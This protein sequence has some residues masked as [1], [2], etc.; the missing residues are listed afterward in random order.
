[1]CRHHISD[2]PG[3]TTYIDIGLALLENHAAQPLLANGF[4]I[5]SSGGWLINKLL[6]YISSLGFVIIRN[7]TPPPLKMPVGKVGGFPRLTINNNR[8]LTA[9][10]FRPQPHDSLCDWPSHRHQA[11]HDAFRSLAYERWNC[12]NAVF[13][14]L[15]K[16]AKI[17][18]IWR[19][20][21]Q[22]GCQL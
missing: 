14:I 1:M 6:P 7:A 4:L 20:T 3:W 5:S 10:L 2:S 15:R 11:L 22:N 13:E 21:V 16:T 9:D 12:K 8:L 18:E 17:K 19:L